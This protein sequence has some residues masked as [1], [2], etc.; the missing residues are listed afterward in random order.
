MDEKSC[1]IKGKVVDRPWS[2]RLVLMEYDADSRVQEPK[3]IIPVRDG[4]FTYV[5]EVDECKMYQLIFADELAKSAYR[6]I[7]FFAEPGVVDIEICFEDGGFVPKIHGGSINGEYQMYLK[8]KEGRFHFQAL[9][10]QYDSLVRQDL[11]FTPLAKELQQLMFQFQEDRLKLDSLNAVYLRLEKE[12]KVYTAQVMALNEKNKCLRVQE[13]KWKEDYIDRNPSL[14]SYFLLM[15]DLRCLM[16]YRVHGF[17]GEFDMLS[18]KDLQRLEDMYYSVYKLMFPEHSYTSLS[19]MM[20]ESLRKIEV[21][22]KYIDF[23]APDLDGHPVTLSQQIDGKVA[24][25]DL[26]ASWCGPCRKHSKS[27]IPVYEKYKSK[28]FTIIGVA[29]EKSVDSAKNAILQDGYPWLNLVEI[30]D[31]GNIWFRYC[32]EGAGGGTF[33]V[34]RDGKIL[35][36]C[37]TAEEVEN[38]L[39]EMLN[40]EVTSMPGWG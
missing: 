37:P 15:D 30:N 4:E 35:A 5:H 32:V 1:V 29:R 22:G 21:G 2:H 18:F 16:K 27:M 19:A 38:I 23:T 25:I 10:A 28:G 12:K 11:Y 26:W 13:Q 6:P 33:L 7:H 39:E 8:D 40:D 31:I 34:D 36:V 3:V 24:L 20:L 17:P 14:V 9:S